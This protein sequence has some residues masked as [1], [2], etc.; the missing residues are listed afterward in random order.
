MQEITKLPIPQAIQAIFRSILTGYFNGARKALK[1]YRIHFYLNEVV[2][3]GFENHDYRKCLV[4]G[5]DYISIDILFRIG[6]LGRGL[7]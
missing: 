3:I 1:K 2:L 5:S 6:Q 7:I 4:K